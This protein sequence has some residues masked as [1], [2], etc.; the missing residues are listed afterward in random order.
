MMDGFKAT[1]ESML[2]ND[3]T[4]INEAGI[5]ITPEQARKVVSRIL[6]HL[7]S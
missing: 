3:W 4:L 6:S 5:E 7:N 2:I 1:T